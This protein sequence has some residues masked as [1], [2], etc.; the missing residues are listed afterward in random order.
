MK[1]A[2]LSDLH[3]GQPGAVE[4]ARRLVEHIR[5]TH[6]DAQIVV[7]GD[8]ADTPTREQVRAMRDVLAGCHVAPGN[9]DTARWGFLQWPGL[10]A[11]WHEEMGLSDD[12]PKVIDVGHVRLIL[13]DSTLDV[14]LRRG[15]LAR[16]RCGRDQLNRVAMALDT[17]R[18]CLAFVH[19]HL[20]EQRTTLEL[21][22][23]DLLLDTLAGGRCLAVFYGHLHTAWEGRYKDVRLFA[24]CKSPSSM[25]YRMTQV[26]GRRLWWWWESVSYS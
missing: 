14:G 10:R 2:H 8:V 6:P 7:S 15:A 22:D 26:D 5:A 18:P 19:H 23:A 13:I 21:I 16:G 20:S 12:W 25:L 17:D 11:M 1:I 24:S 9:H 3:A 4:R